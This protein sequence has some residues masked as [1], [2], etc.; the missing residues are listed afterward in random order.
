MYSVATASFSSPRGGVA[1]GRTARL[2]CPISH[3]VMTG[4]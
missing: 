1:M 2:T 4:Q 3:G